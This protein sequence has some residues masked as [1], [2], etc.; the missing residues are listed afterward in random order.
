MN[1]WILRIGELPGFP[2]LQAGKIR[3]KLA[4]GFR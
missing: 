4:P 1:R 3:V 2:G